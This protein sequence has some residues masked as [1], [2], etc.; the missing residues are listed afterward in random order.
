MYARRQTRPKPAQ[1]IPTK[2]DAPVA[3]WVSNRAL[4]S[5]GAI[6]G[7]G[8]EILDNFFPRA[9]GVALRRGKQ[10]YATLEDVE[11]D[12]TALFTYKDGA[13]EKMFGANATTIYD[14][15]T[16][17][18][19][20][21]ALLAANDEGDVLG[22]EDG[23]VFGWFST[24]G[25]DVA[26]GFTSGDWSVAQFTT[27]GGSYLVGVNG[28]DT[29]FIY[30]GSEFF[31]YVK[32]GV[33]AV[34]YDAEVS[35]FEAG[36]I[37]V[38][39]ES[40]AHGTVWKNVP[41]DPGEG[42]LYLTDVTEL[43]MKWELAYDGGSGAFAPG[44]TVTG[45]DSGATAVVESVDGDATS[46][47]LTLIDLVGTF[48]NDEVITGD[49][50][51][52]AVA[53]GADSYLSGGPFRDN[54]GLTGGDSGEATAAGDAELAVPGVDFGTLD[55]SDMSYVWAYNERLYFAQTDALSAWYLDVDSIGGTATEFP[56]VGVFDLGGSLLFGQRWSLESG[57]EGGLS[58]QNIFVSTQGE[59]AIY[60][61]FSPDEAD[62]WRLVGVY[63][64]GRPLGKHAF[65]RGGGDLAIATTVG[66]VPL[67]KAISLD[68]TALNVA[69]VSY[70][71]ADAW[72]E[73]VQQRGT[74]NWR[75]GIWP[76]QK[77]AIV[78][79]PDLQGSSSPVMFVSNTETGAWTR[80]RGW[81][82]LCMTVFQG[83]LYFGSPEGKV[84]KANV[85]GLDDGAAYSGVVVP[86]FSD[87]G[88][89]ASVKVGTMAR[90]Q[91]RANIDVVDRVDILTDYNVTTL[92]AAPDATPITA[93][94]VWG[95][96]VWGASVWSSA[97]PT[98]IGVKWRS[99]GGVGYTLA[100]CYQ[101]TSGSI[102][103]LDLELISME[104]LHTPAGL[105]S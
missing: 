40:G 98:V 19:N 78:A 50:S 36:E 75:A 9:T 60:Q 84:F 94:N 8:A 5:P 79:P 11:E 80:F 6:E 14:L 2:W 17:T 10:R 20:E 3:G 32:G 95:E 38:G 89:P 22:T 90:A 64:I 81:Q 46:G 52:A 31:P 47:T 66:L 48:Q 43:P 58:D 67:S 76:E 61:G 41:G 26:G 88:S 72:T 68:V 54:E 99:A 23:D 102:G 56:L 12:V 42:V 33:T 105:A 57:G 92:P 101:I 100:P 87:L 29:G 7:P 39:D 1:A 21:D 16:V 63:R 24:T 85:G 65:V 91:T 93:S 71:I 18:F 53:D 104:T 55:S 82:A 27:T 30:D 37:V 4:A 103:P 74:S 69:T 62:T 49:D 34:P 59:V 35:A 86:L 77:M 44:E 70:K 45:A 96:G 13:T 28:V 25:L 97:T 73:A 83:Q 51:G 15:T